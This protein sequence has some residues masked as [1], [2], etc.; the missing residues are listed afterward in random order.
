MKAGMVVRKLFRIAFALFV[1]SHRIALFSHRIRIFHSHRTFRTFFSHFRTFSTFLVD[2]SWSM[3]QKV[4]K[5]ARKMRETSKK[6]RQY[7]NAK[8]SKKCETMRNANTMGKWNQNSHRIAL[9]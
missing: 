3:H 5:S 4:M 1:E 9:L 6:V 7:E 2:I 8:N